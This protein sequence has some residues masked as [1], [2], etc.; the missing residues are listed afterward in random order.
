MEEPLTESEEQVWRQRIQ[1]EEVGRTWSVLGTWEAS[2]SRRQPDVESD[3]QGKW[4]RGGLG[5]QWA[6]TGV[7]EEAAKGTEA[8]HGPWEL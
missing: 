4:L 8:S 2:T 5:C 3:V 1:L 6:P 7:K